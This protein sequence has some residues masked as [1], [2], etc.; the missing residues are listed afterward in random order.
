MG[1]FVRFAAG[2]A[3]E[4]EVQLLW[5]KDPKY[6]SNDVFHALFEKTTEV[7]RMETAFLARLKPDN[8]KLVPAPIWDWRVRGLG[9]S[10]KAR[11]ENPTPQRFGAQQRRAGLE[12]WA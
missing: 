4:I 5:A 3:S 7:K 9:R 11:T 10:P 6:V 8:R 1:R 12:N 2:Y